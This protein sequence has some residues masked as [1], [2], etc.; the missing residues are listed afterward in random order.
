MIFQNF[1]MAL[2]SI[3]HSKLRS[4]LTILGV[5]IGIGSVVSVIA[6]GDGFKVQ[7]KKEIAKL[8]ID[9]VSVSPVDGGQAFTPTD[10]TSIQ[11]ASGVDTVVPFMYVNG[12]ASFDGKEAKDTIIT[13]TSSQ[14]SKIITEPL[15]SGRY[16]DE[17]ERNVVVIGGNVAQGLFGKDDAVGKT[18]IITYSVI[19]KSTAGLKSLQIPLKVIGV[20]KKPT[21]KSTFGLGGQHNNSLL[22]S[23][24]D[25]KDL[26]SGREYISLISAKSV[27]GTD[28]KTVS[29]NITG[30]LKNAHKGKQDFELSTAEDVAKSFNDTLNGVTKFIAAVAAISLLVG[31]I[32][33]MNIML[34]SVAERTRE[35]GIRKALGAKRST[36][37]M[38]F[39]I[40]S[41]TLTLLGGILGIFAAFG[42]AHAAAKQVKV[43]PYFSMRAYIIA[44]GISV[45]IGVIFGVVPALQAARKK[46]IDALR[47][48]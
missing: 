16:F 44:I 21:E 4:F 11:K 18:I 36:I 8:G 28:I 46:P 2:V 45:A 43:E 31:G 39:L 7:L 42:I 38:Q 47:H 5:V 19:D 14:V 37:L 17:N 23:M 25:G 40:E 26:N 12:K 13:A 1:R 33:I 48:E 24:P 9:I 22:I 30:E 29:Q 15:E 34:S 10:V 35:I 32:G 6:V 20:I 41:L 3:S 27:S